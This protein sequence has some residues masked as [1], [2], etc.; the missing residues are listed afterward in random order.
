MPDGRNLPAGL[1]VSF[2]TV[3]LDL[4]S[5]V[6]DSWWRSSSKT[7]ANHANRQE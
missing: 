3:P 7:H 5:L 6:S 4:N 2:Q 1:V